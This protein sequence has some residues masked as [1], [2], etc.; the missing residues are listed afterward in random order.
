[1]VVHLQ[2]TI[3]TADG[4]IVIANENEN[5]DLFW[6]VRGGGSNFGVCTEFVLKLYPQRRTVYAGSIIFPFTSLKEVVETTESWKKTIPTMGAMIQFFAVG[7]DGQVRQP[8][9]VIFIL[10]VS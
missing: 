7:P 1:L 4:S 6:A 10:I 2:V 3:V 8:S 9:L 5:E